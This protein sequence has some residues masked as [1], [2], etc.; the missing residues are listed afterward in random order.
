[1]AWDR[2][3]NGTR[4]STRR[5][6]SVTGQDRKSRDTDLKSGANITLVSKTGSQNFHGLGSYFKRHEE[7]NAT[8]FFR[9]RTGQK[10]P[11]YRYNTWTYNIGGPVYI[12]NKFNRNKDKLFFFWNQEFW[13]LQSAVVGSVTTPTALERTGDFSQTVDLNR[14]LIPIKDPTNGLPFPGNVVPANRLNASGVSLL[15]MFPL[16]NFLDFNTS[17]GAYNYNFTTPVSKPTRM[18][19]LRLDYNINSNNRISGSYY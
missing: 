8:D 6:S 13:P 9:N 15:K 1:M 14:A 16:P 4:S 5:I 7:F 19:T 10:K 2:T 11:R 17:K 3:S 18:E 12:P